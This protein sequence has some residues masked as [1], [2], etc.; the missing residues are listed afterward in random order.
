MKTRYVHIGY[1]KT[2]TTSLQDGFFPRHR[3]LFH[4]GVPFIAEDIQDAIQIDILRKD[5]LTY[6]PRKVEK[7]FGPYLEKAEQDPRCRAVGISYEDLSFFADGGTVDR[8]LV[9][10]RLRLLLGEAKVIIVV[11]NQFDFIRSLYS[12]SLRGGCYF[13]FQQYLEAHYWG[14]YS[15]LFNQ[16]FYHR[17]V[18]CY[19]KLF[20]EEQVKVILFEELWR[21]PQEVLDGLCDFLGVAPTPVQLPRSNS[22]LSWLSLTALRVANR[23]F[24]NNYGRAYFMPITPGSQ[25]PGMQRELGFTPRGLEKR[26]SWRRLLRQQA[27]RLDRKLSLKPVK[28]KFSEEWR[29]RITDLY[30]EDNQ[31]LMEATGLGLRRYQYPLA[32]AEEITHGDHA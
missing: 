29:R 26:D 23:V 7:T 18:Q 15:Y 25:A 19:Q 24:K 27:S 30:A 22:S 10:E 32:G 1:P 20:G 9:A 13:S 6:C 4:L 8:G 16:I 31:R 5:S 28:L 12:E 2:G 21:H 17:M 3:E 14:F 11:R